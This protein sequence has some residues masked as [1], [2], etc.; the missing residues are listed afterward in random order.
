MRFSLDRV[1]WAVRRED[2]VGLFEKGR[3]LYE[4]AIA[5]VEE[6][7]LDFRLLLFIISPMM[8]IAYSVVKFIDNTVDDV[9]PMIVYFLS[10]L[11][12][13]VSSSLS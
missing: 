1:G 2:G 3:G 8:T 4:G 7:S 13:L 10:T 6:N 9:G 12:K 11:A 5:F